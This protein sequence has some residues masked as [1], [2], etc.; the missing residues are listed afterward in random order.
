MPGKKD[1][2]G[3]EDEVL[4]RCRNVAERRGAASSSRR[5]QGGDSKNKEGETATGERRDARSG[6]RVHLQR[7]SEKVYHFE[8]RELWRD[9]RG[10]FTREGDGCA[11][12]STCNSTK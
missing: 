3:E 4:V 11:G 7:P 9:S 10:C 8:P 1:W 6:G 12:R 2:G 5:G